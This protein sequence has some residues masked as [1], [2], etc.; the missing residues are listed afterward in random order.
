MKG[1][2][3]AE[4]LSKAGKLNKKEILKSFKRSLKEN[5]LV[6]L[7]KNAGGKKEH[8]SGLN[9]EIKETTEEK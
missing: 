4:K 7:T 3:A 2:A 8:K 6:I 1:S 5:S 9:K